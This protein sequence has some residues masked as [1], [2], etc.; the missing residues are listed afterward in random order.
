MKR[1]M[2]HDWRTENGKQRDLWILACGVALAV[3]LACRPLFAG[4]DGIGGVFGGLFSSQAH[5]RANI[6][7]GPELVKILESTPDGDVRMVM[8]GDAGTPPTPVTYKVQPRSSFR[9]GDR[10][11]RTF[12][13][14]WATADYA[15]ESFRIACKGAD[16]TWR[17]AATPQAEGAN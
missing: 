5:G 3:I 1:S 10:Q 13:M 14:H 16:G 2:H 7:A 9:I 12:V 8:L 15:N 4:Q 11:C 17:V 6:V